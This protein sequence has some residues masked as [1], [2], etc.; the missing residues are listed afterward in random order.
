MFNKQA[1]GIEEENQCAPE[2]RH[3]VTIEYPDNGEPV[4]E[5]GEISSQPVIIEAQDQDLRRS[6]RERRPPDFYGVRVNITS[7][8]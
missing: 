3:V 2:Q 1:R 5:G 8:A 7:E 6:E 4:H